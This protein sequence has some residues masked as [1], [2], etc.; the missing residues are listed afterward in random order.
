[1]RTYFLL[2]IELEDFFAAD[3]V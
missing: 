1:M 3:K 2:H